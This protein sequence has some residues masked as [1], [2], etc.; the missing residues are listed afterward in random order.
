MDVSKISGNT[1]N[2]VMSTWNKHGSDVRITGS[3]I[4]TTSDD[5]AQVLIGNGRIQARN[6]SGST[7]GQI[8]Y[9]AD[10]GSPNMTVTTSLGAH[11]LVR[12]HLGSGKYTDLFKL[13]AG[14]T[15]ARFSVDKVLN[16]SGKFRAYEFENRYGGGMYATSGNLTRI[17]S[18]NNLEFMTHGRNHA[19]RKMKMDNTRIYMYNTLNMDGNSIVSSPSISDERMKDVQGM[20]VENDLKKLM[21]IEYVNFKW[22]EE[23]YGGQDLGF[24]AQQVETL[25]PEMMMESKD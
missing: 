3:G 7:I 16:N 24:I 1:T 20:R 15:T 25:I 19:D 23:E 6:P 12:N 22:K 21:Q 14:G 2:F 9:H 13:E 5:S 8:G 10:A 18:G 11:F 4:L 17:Y